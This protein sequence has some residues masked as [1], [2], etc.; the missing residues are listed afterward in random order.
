VTNRASN[1]RQRESMHALKSEAQG[2]GAKAARVR[3]EDA[4]REEVSRTSK[5]RLEEWATLPACKGVHQS[6]HLCRTTHSSFLLW[7]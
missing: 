1:Y 5:A 2:I 6:T 3:E 7:A 4:D